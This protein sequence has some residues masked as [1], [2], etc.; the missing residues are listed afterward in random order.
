MVIVKYNPEWPRQFERLTQEIT[1]TVTQ[2][3][4]IEHIGSTAIPGMY[5]KPI[6]DMN[7]K[8][9]HRDSFCLIKEELT[10]IGYFHN[11]NQG[12]E[13][14]EVFKRSGKCVND[15][16]D[17]I[18]HH[19]Y[20]GTADSREFQRNVL[21]RDYLKT[22][23]VYVEKYNQIKMDILKEYGEHNRAKYVEV[24]ERDYRWFFEDVIQ[25]RCVEM[26][27]F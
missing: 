19:L 15:A 9:A 17:T 11:G 22:H 14:R 10:R 1:K 4:N 6:I 25:K 24:K 26:M 8:I 23:P 16:L 21:F 13:G 27:M 3:T 5:A 2:Y 12:I 7:I 18:R 20:V